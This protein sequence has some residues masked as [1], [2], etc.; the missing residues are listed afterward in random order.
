ML[1]NPNYLP[2]LT[3]YLLDK[4]N[5][6][7]GRDNF[8]PLNILMKMKSTKKYYENLRGY[9]DTLGYDPGTQDYLVAV[10]NGI[11]GTTAVFHCN[12]KQLIA[13]YHNREYCL[14][15]NRGPINTRL[16]YEFNSIESSMSGLIDP[17]P[18]LDII[19]HSAY[20]AM[21]LNLRNNIPPL[22]ES[23]GKMLLVSKSISN[24]KGYETYQPS[25]NFSAPPY[26]LGA[27][28]EDLKL[29]YNNLPSFK[30]KFDQ[31]R[32][33]GESNS[34]AKYVAVAAIYKAKGEDIIK[35]RLRI[36]YIIEQPYTNPKG[37][38]QSMLG[39]EFHSTLLA[40]ARKAETF[41]DSLI[42]N[43]VYGHLYESVVVNTTTISPITWQNVVK[44]SSYI[45]RYHKNEENPKTI[46]QIYSNYYYKKWQVPRNDM[47]HPYAERGK[48]TQGSI[49]ESNK[50]MRDKRLK[51][52]SY[53][54]IAI[55]Y[56]AMAKNK[57]EPSKW[58]IPHDVIVFPIK[59]YYHLLADRFMNLN[60]PSK[61]YMI[62]PKLLLLKIAIEYLYDNNPQVLLSHYCSWDSIC[63][64]VET[65]ENH[66]NSYN[67]MVNR[68]SNSTITFSPTTTSYNYHS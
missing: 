61:S 41:I 55:G 45:K 23:P 52:D 27:M 28:K 11:T 40:N 67:S 65:I 32:A 44:E 64:W 21:C 58:N 19:N 43:E 24:P 12:T 14:R 18:E 9:L 15:V 20:Y 39:H 10:D 6:F 66:Y 62:N 5:L 30:Q 68:G 22:Q 48:M 49:K 17:T 46:A 50:Y 31:F 13:F 35:D 47:N 38:R 57:V 54:S 51:S 37:F 7:T 25:V 26:P 42:Q 29:I 56:W 8:S 34:S 60:F 36:N 4:A 3:S 53:D 16:E 63:S 33:N 59:E 1:L 2:E